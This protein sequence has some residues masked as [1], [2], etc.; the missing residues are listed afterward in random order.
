MIKERKQNVIIKL[1]FIEDEV[2]DGSIHS[3]IKI[4]FDLNNSKHITALRE[5]GLEKEVKK[6]QEDYK[7]LNGLR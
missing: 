3:T 2:I 6:C 4:E 5:M 7:W 1:G